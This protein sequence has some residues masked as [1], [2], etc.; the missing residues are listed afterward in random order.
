M[1]LK[2]LQQV[3][4]PQGITTDEAARQVYGQDASR[5]HGE[6]LAIVW[7]ETAN[8]VSALA[9]WATTEGVDLTPRGAG[10]GLC[11]GAVP[12]GSVVVDASRLTGLDL[13]VPAVPRVR[14]GAGLAVGAL[15]RYLQP[16]RLFFP[17]VP[18][19]HRTATLGGMLATNAAGLHAVRYGVMS[20]WVEQATL[21]DGRG[22]VNVLRGEQLAAVAGR[23]GATG[24]LVELT[25]RLAPLPAERTLTR[26]AFETTAAL[27]EQRAAWL[28]DPRLTAL[29]YL[30]RHA[31]AAI[32]WA[33]RPHLFAEFEGPEGELHGDQVDTLW[34]ERDGLYPQLARAGYPMIEDPRLDD[35]GLA[36][37][38]EWL[39]D[40]H[41]PV[42]GH[43]GLG[44][45]H[46]CFPPDD[47][48]VAQLY[49]RV[50]EAGG[51][52]SGEHGIGLKKKAWVGETYR[53]EIRQLKQICDPRG[54]FNRGKPC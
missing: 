37:L 42:F 21:V 44:L 27:L 51:R 8:Q 36:G 11:G 26:Q 31:A 48:R 19:S 16:H 13:P 23:E 39:D 54:V 52:V 5:M 10:T 29:E 38:L 50:A 3:F 22:R 40:E 9:Q 41:I 12:Q 25:L 32:G 7:P 20:D 46:P 45:L 18:G 33:V 24:F 53:D 47:T 30:N 43:L 49:Q 17:V 15:N 1:N 34:R 35:A 6:C 28:A 14:V 2:P 4:G